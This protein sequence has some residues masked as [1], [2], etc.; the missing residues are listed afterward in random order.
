VAV[1]ILI[2]GHGLNIALATIAIFAHGVRLNMLE[3]SNHAGVQW[4]GYAY[5]PF[6]TEKNNISGEDIIR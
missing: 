2:F 6:N 5:R 4:N 3:F 1:P